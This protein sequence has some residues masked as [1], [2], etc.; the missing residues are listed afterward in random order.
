MHL[1]SRLPK[2]N[3][4]SRT[5]KCLSLFAM[6]ALSISAYA[7]T[8][9]SAAADS[10]LNS[11]ASA[12]A[13]QDHVA[14]SAAE[15]SSV[16]AALTKSIDT[17]NAHVG[18]Q[19]FAKTTSAAVLTDGTR[20]PKGTK[21]VG[22]V[23][24]VKAKSSADK[25]SHLAFSL[26][27]AILHDGREIPVH[28]T[29]TSLAAPAAALNPTDDLSAASGPVGGGAPAGGRA[30][31]GGGLGGGLVGGATQAAGGAGNLVGGTTRGIESA[32]NGA[33]Q[34]VAATEANGANAAGN[35]TGG[36]NSTSNLQPIA[37]MPGVTFS[38][39]A[40]QGTTA[41]LSAASRNINLESGSQLTLDLSAGNQ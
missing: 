18:D 37:N 13:R 31:G 12:S 1:R 24:D 41:S 33:V 4:R 2:I 32:A 23:T 39:A 19:V 36:V 34:T 22:Q 3:T 9:T 7:Q 15:A 20:L 14:S 30:S 6:A 29:L 26:D 17:K 25:T 16:S 21:L 5:M 8:P 10:T 40:S 27:R 38:N 35:L 11:A 28:T